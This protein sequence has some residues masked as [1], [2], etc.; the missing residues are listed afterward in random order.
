MKYSVEFHCTG[1]TSET[2]KVGCDANMIDADQFDILHYFLSLKQRINYLQL[3]AS[4]LQG[5]SSGPV[6]ERERESAYLGRTCW[7][8]AQS[9]QNYRPATT[10][11]VR[12][13]T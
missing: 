7:R 10:E 2:R 8:S 4:A 12:V 5:I 6:S 11:S 9:D 13:I 3:S 1:L